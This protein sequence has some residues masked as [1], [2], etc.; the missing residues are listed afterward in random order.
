VKCPEFGPGLRPDSA[1]P[2]TA[3]LVIHSPPAD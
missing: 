2:S 3:R 1:P